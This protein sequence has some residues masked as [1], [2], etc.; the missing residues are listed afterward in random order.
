V[1][2]DDTLNDRLARYHQIKVTWSGGGR[3]G[4]DGDSACEQRTLQLQRSHSTE[5]RFLL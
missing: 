5:L 1:I 4:S 3:G 2:A